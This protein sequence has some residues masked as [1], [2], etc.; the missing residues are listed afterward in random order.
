MKILIHSC[1]NWTNVEGINSMVSNKGTCILKTVV[2]SF[3]CEVYTRGEEGAEN[4]ILVLID[5]K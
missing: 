5:P 2:W 1:K 3:K 4:L